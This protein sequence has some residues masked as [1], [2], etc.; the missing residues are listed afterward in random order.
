MNIFDLINN[1]AFDKKHITDIDIES[2]DSTNVYMVNR[3]VSMID[4]S[5]ANIINNTLNRYHS[6]FTKKHDA[7]NFLKDVLPKYPRQR[8]YYIKK[9]K[10]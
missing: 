7:F 6:I 2:E 9:P 4:S 5:A 10:A 1:I 8:I 3:W